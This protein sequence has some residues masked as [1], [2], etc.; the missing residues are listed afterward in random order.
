MESILNA[1]CLCV[2]ET[3]IAKT[4]IGHFVKDC[5]SSSEVTERLYS[6][7]QILAVSVWM[8]VSALIS[9]ELL[10]LCICLPTLAEQTGRGV[11]VLRELKRAGGLIRRDPWS[12]WRGVGRSSLSNTEEK[13][14]LSTCTHAKTHTKTN[15]KG[16]Q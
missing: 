5:L 1:V 11:N 4:T 2:C 8:R 13:S 16:T 10:A 3:Y 15:K 9:D 12:G 14:S 7:K 6:S